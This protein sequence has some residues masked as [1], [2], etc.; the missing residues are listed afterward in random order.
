MSSCFVIVDALV[1]MLTCLSLKP[2]TE[3]TDLIIL[4]GPPMTSMW[5]E[6]VLAEIGFELIIIFIAGCNLSDIIRIIIPVWR[7]ESPYRVIY[8]SSE[9]PKNAR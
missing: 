1:V 2:L 6:S 3:T 7:R 5:F 4:S 8:C 9:Q